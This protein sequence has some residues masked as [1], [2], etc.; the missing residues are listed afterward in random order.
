MYPRIPFPTDESLYEKMADLGAELMRLHLIP[1]TITIKLELADISP[2]AWIIRDFVYIP[3]EETL[4]F[5]N[6]ENYSANEK[7]SIP[8]IHGITFMVWNYSIGCIPQLA[9]FLES[10]KYCPNQKWN[11]LQRGLNHEEL[12]YFLK[13]ATIFENVI[14][15]LSDLDVV[16]QSIDILNDD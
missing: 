5:D 15:I 3:E 9:Q 7:N 11:C 16:Y 12:L 13:L 1:E 6:P 2:D 8:W 14:K 10:R 4:Y